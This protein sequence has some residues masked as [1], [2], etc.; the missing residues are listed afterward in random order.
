[1]WPGITLA[2]E[3]GGLQFSLP[4]MLR[5]EGCP[6]GLSACCNYPKLDKVQ[7]SGIGGHTKN[8][9]QKTLCT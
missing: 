3:A 5:H 7:T 2:L 4:S 9:L 1:M 6:I 8:Y